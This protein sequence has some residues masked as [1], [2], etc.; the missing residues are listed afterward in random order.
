MPSSRILTLLTQ[1]P[2]AFES[3]KVDRPVYKASRSFQGYPKVI[4]VMFR[5]T[6]RS[7][8]YEPRF[9]LATRY[10]NHVFNFSILELLFTIGIFVH[11][12]T[13]KLN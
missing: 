12:N 9:S 1:I 7:F 4:A 10:A 3:E 13:S 6:F 2:H 11:I 5:Q 8:I